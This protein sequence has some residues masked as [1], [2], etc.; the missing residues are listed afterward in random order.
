MISDQ[1]A[2]VA[3]PDDDDKDVPMDDEVVAGD[4]DVK[5]EGDEPHIKQ[6]NT[7]ENKPGALFRPDYGLVA[8]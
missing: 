2:K 8:Y 6:E 7:P 4:D 5:E 3:V 1:F